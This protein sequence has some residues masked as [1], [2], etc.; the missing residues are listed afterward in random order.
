MSCFLCNWR[1]DVFCRLAKV[2]SVEVI[3]FVFWK[4]HSSLCPCFLIFLL[5][6]LFVFAYRCEFT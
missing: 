3:V 1:L 2:V 4:S 6:G 5:V